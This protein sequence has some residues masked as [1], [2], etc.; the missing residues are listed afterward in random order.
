MG[1][2]VGIKGKTVGRYLMED[3]AW[4]L[5]MSTVGNKQKLVGT[6]LNI[7]ILLDCYTAICKWFSASSAR[8]CACLW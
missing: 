8:H 7:P 4:Q 6:V 2:E 5:S 1:I 3:G